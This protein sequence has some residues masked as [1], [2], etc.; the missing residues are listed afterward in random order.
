GRRSRSV[1]VPR[2]CGV[3]IT[4]RGFEDAITASLVQTGGYR[5]CK[6]G[7][8]ADWVADFDRA[9]GLDTAELFA[10][11]AETQPTAWERLVAVHGGE[12]GARTQFG[13]RLAK[14]LDERG[15]GHILRQG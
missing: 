5:V 4:E 12:D 11:I 2:G 14:E 6:W 10:F 7:T 13:E 15:A 3:T 1:R 8:H 9:L